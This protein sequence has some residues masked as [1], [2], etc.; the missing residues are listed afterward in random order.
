MEI[1]LFSMILIKS[2]SN[3][4]RNVSELADLISEY[5]SH[6]KLNEVKRSAQNPD[7]RKLSS[8]ILD[9]PGII[10]TTDF[11]NLYPDIPVLYHDNL[12]SVKTYCKKYF[13]TNSLKPIH[14]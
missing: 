10:N 7:I 13:N 6:F 14:P 4:G 11:Q 5:Y 1:L 8:E 2:Y 9:S 12:E 3:S